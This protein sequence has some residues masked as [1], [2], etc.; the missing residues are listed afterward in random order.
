MPDVDPAFIKAHKELTNPEYALGTK[1][2]ILISDGDH[3]DASPGVLAKLVKA[4][5]TCTTVCITSHGQ[6]EVAKDG[7]RR[8]R[9]CK[10]P[11]L[12]HQ[13]SAQTPR[14][15]HPGNRLVSQSFVHEKQ[16]QPRVVG[17]REGPTEG[18][19]GDPPPL[20]GF[21]RT[22]P[23]ESSLVKVLMETPTKIGEYKFPIL[24]AWQY[25]LGKSVAFTSDARTSQGRQS[26]LGPRMGRRGDLRQVLGRRPST[27]CCARPRP[28]S[29]C[30]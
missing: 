14:D 9:F 7:R 30:S 3:W 26:V 29:T 6:A 2:I 17:L 8:H 21:V 18:M 16:F 4:K 20:Y 24:A 12:S 22:T 23:K 27:G 5:I 1:H 19:S 11:R 15:L 25:G 10:G 13:G 28:A